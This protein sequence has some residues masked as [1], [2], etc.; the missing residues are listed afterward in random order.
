MFDIASLRSTLP[1]LIWEQ[2]VAG[3]SPVAPTLISGWPTS[4]GGDST[5]SRPHTA[6]AKTPSGFAA[7][8]ALVSGRAKSISSS[9]RPRPPSVRQETDTDP[10]D[11]GSCG[12]YGLCPVP[13]VR[14]GSADSVDLLSPASE[15]GSA[16]RPSRAPLDEMRGMRRAPVCPRSESGR[17][18]GRAST[19]TWADAGAQPDFRIVLLMPSRVRP[20]VTGEGDTRS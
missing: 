2:G 19:R 12:P 7:R 9:R 5:G 1:R 15:C 13:T 8:K 3:S 14:N 16:A 6:D 18:S 17:R 10:R 4:P 20:R 11:A